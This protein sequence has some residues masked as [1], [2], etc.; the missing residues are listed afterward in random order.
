M[1]LSEARTV[2]TSGARLGLKKEAA[3]QLPGFEHHRRFSCAC[4]VTGEA[5]DDAQR[6]S[7]TIRSR[8]ARADGPS[9]FLPYPPGHRLAGHSQV[10]ATELNWAGLLEERGWD[11]NPVRCPACKA[12]LTVQ[13]YKSAR[14]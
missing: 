10:A 2:P 1:G 12:G 8:T 6:T 11:S 5:S 9:N 3:R 13:A 4:T 7:I 14:R